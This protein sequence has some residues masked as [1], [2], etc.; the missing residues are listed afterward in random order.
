MVGGNKG[1]LGKV[2]FRS[3]K[4]FSSASLDAKMTQFPHPAKGPNMKRFIVFAAIAVASS[5]AFAFK[6]CEELKTEIA[7]KIDANG[8]KD[9]TLDI[10]PND[11]VG[12]KKVV[13][14]CEGG[15]KK[16]VYSKK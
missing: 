7:A 4:L 13:G 8:V 12:E 5:H 1:P 3:G 15:T 6:P 2:C 16:I 11:Q 14:S 9:Y 10:V